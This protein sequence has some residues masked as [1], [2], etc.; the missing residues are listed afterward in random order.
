MSHQINI[1][2]E[3]GKASFF[4]AKEKAWHGLG[5]YVEEALSSEDAIKAA[6][7]DYEV[8]KAKDISHVNVDGKRRTVSNPWWVQ[9]YRT[10][11]LEGFGCVGKNYQVIQ[12]A[13]MFDF[14]DEIVGKGAAIF[15]T[16]GALGRGER[17]FITAKMPQ[18]IVLPGDDVV[19]Q[20]L[21]AFGSHD[22]MSSN[23]FAFTPVRVVCNNTLNAAL[24][25]LSYKYR[26]RHTGNVE[27]KMAMAARVM[28][29]ANKLSQA[30][31][32]IFQRMAATPVVDSKLKQLRWTT[33][34]VSTDKVAA[35]EVA[36]R[37]QN[38]FD[39]ILEYNFADD[40]QKTLA[41][42]GTLFGVYN[43]VTG[44][45]NNQTAYKDAEHR[46][47]SLAEGTGHEYAQKAFNACLKELN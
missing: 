34:G 19:D 39:E 28:G 25:N 21:L 30:T 5:Q 43:A 41:T 3:T 9:T 1:N 35:G 6:G 44:Y 45:F 36:A 20:Y 12:N 10:D 11:T 15:E 26:I 38:R 27:E 37:T 46:F 17:V 13:Q 16:A 14:F 22:S 29:I 42:K 47:L 2:S 18:H 33:L 7:L 8:A 40:T 23:F 4:A 24:R 31:E 32:D